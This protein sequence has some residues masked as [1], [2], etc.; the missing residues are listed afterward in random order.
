M[1]AYSRLNGVPVSS[2]M[3]TQIHLPLRLGGHGFTA[4]SPF[5]YA[6][7]ASS[8]IESAHVRVKGPNNPS[9]TFYRRMGRQFLVHFVGALN[10]EVRTRGV[11]GTHSSLGLFELDALLSRPERVHKTIFQAMHGA[12]SRLYWENSSW[13]RSPRPRDHTAVSVRC[14]ARYNSLM[15]P[16]ASSFL[17]AHPSLTSRVSNAMWSCMLLGHLDTLVYPDS[18]PSLIFPHYRQPTNARADHAAICCNG[19]EVVHR[20]NTV[21]NFLSRYAFRAA[22]LCSDLEV[23]SLLPG[24]AHRPADIFVQPPPP[25]AAALPECPIAYDVTIRSPYRRAS[26][27]LAARGLA[28]AAE[29]SHVDKLR[30]HARIVQDAFHLPSDASLPLLE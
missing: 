25:P 15:V 18:I 17:C 14:R 20:H 1:A 3:V 2:S 21:R 19:F 8:L 13:N 24:T 11:S 6:A 22:G 7:Y 26:L 4:L 10:P 12:I 29:A 27:S 5:V 23:Q 28:G 9:E 30:V 16:G